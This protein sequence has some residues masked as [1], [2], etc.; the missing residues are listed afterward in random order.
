MIVIDASAVVELLL[1]SSKG[2]RIRARLDSGAPQ[3]HAPQLVDLEVTS[4]LRKAV[5]LGVLP[6]ARAELALKDLQDLQVLRH[7]HLPL[8]GRIWALRHNLTAYDAV[9]VAL[10]EALR[11][12]L[13]TCDARLAAASGARAAVEV[14]GA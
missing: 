8:L 2:R 14:V 11:A 12:P 3:L 1:A 10:A 13:L 4:A 7:G 5:R 9:Y 6:Q